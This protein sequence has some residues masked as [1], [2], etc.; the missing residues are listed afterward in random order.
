MPREFL[1]LHHSGSFSGFS[2]TSMT[3]PFSKAEGVER[4]N[5]VE[6]ST[7]A[8]CTPVSQQSPLRASKEASRGIALPSV[9][10]SSELLLDIIGGKPAHAARLAAPPPAVT[11]LLHHDHPGA[12]DQGQLVIP[13]CHVGKLDHSWDVEVVDS[14]GSS[15]NPSTP[16]AIR[17]FNSNMKETPSYMILDVY[18]VTAI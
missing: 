12:L 17:G 11:A 9:V 6:H 5:Q 2:T 15:S 18:T 7:T 1:H 13:L 14:L 10:R 3:S 4:L 8:A 16:A